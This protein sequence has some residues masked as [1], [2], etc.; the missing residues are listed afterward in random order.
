M[1]PELEDKKYEIIKS[2]CLDPEN[3]QLSEKDKEIFERWISASKILD[4][5]PNRRHAVALQM[6]KFPAISRETA[7]LDMRQ[8][9][10]LF[11]SL[12][13]FDYDWWHQWLL[14]D[15]S[16]QIIACRESGDRKNWAAGHSNLIKALGEKP[17]EIV[18]PKRHEKKEVYLAIQINNKTV[19]IDADKLQNLQP[20]TYK[21]LIDA[22]TKDLDIEDA[23]EIMNT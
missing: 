21:T 1:K 20:G 2:H 5:Y 22:L 7:Y 17:E 14:N 8:A 13:T 6:T 23:E 12:Q 11:N 4:N 9:A 18:D 16:K 15:I 3:S 10:R 19:K